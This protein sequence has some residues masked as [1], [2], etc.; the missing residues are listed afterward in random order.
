MGQRHQIYIRLPEWKSASGNYDRPPYWIGLHHQWCYG[1]TCLRFL[2]NTFR[3]YE[4]DRVSQYPNL[5]TD[6][7]APGLLNAIWGF[8][9][10]L[11]IYSPSHITHGNGQSDFHITAD[12]SK[13]YVDGSIDPYLG[14]NND[15]ITV[16][17]FANWEKP[18][19]C[20]HTLEGTEVT[21]FPGGLIKSAREF[22]DAAYPK[23]AD[24]YDEGSD[25]I[26][27]D[28]EIVEQY[29]LLT[30]SDMAGF[31]ATALEEAA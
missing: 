30:E 6:A 29:P 21:A 2:S 15:G 12:Q 26:R 5:K 20:H 23:W 8:D 17:D 27:R 16:I 14:D 28:L 3:Y 22:I 10:D 24:D 19:Y 7:K 1:M 11:P 25:G 9:M 4:S 31:F 18:R 13:V